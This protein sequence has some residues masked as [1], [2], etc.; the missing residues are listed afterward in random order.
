MRTIVTIADKRAL[1]SAD[2]KRTLERITNVEG[3]DKRM[4]DS[5]DSA[6]SRY[7][8]HPSAADAL[9]QCSYLSDLQ[10]E[11]EEQ[12]DAELGVA[13]F[14]RQL[15]TLRE[16]RLSIIVRLPV[17][18]SEVRLLCGL[19][20]S[21][22]SHHNREEGGTGKAWVQGRSGPFSNRRDGAAAWLCGR[23]AW[24]GLNPSPYVQN[25]PVRS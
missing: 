1:Y 15:T 11:A 22:Y 6:G 25:R 2:K 10:R 3:R 14:K 17:T 18:S 4:Q 19:P 20:A 21:I 13:A 12:K 23:G 9:I 5:R 8:Y 24:I 16:R 7:G